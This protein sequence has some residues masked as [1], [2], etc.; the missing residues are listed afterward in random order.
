MQS[1]NPE[2][3]DLL[4]ASRNRHKL[5]EYSRMADKF[6]VIL[7]KRLRIITLD[8]LHI[9]HPEV[10]ETAETYEENALLKA[11]AYA[12]ASGIPVIGDDSGLEVKALDGA[13][14]VRSARCAPGS[15]SDRVAWLLDRMSGVSDRRAR[16]V[17]CVVVAMPK[18]EELGPEHK[19]F[20]FEGVCEGVIADAP[21]GTNGFGFDP[22]F[23]P[24]GYTE[25]FAEMDGDVKDEIS[26]RGIA[27]R[28]VA[29][30]ML[31]VLKYVISKCDFAR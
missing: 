12:D 8:D 29:V 10:D 22:V 3:M 17:A 24:D 27:L 9:A 5:I 30:V 15:D 14:G 20:A 2:A 7:G 4:L 28:G 16:F 26:H 6:P 13:P 31:S 18:C 1:H 23:I 11:F 19:Y 25:T 21:R